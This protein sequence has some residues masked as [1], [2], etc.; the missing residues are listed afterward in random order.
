MT[1]LPLRAGARGARLLAFG[2][3]RPA[4]VVANDDLA[5]VM[6]TSDAW[7]RERTGI[8]TRHLAAPDE[9]V[10]TM[11]AAATAKALAASGV[12]A[13]EVDLVLLATCSA[14]RPIPGGAASVAATVGATSAG[15]VDVNAAC[16][17][18]CY[19][20]SWAADAVRSGSA[21]HVVVA[22]SERLSTWVD[23]TDRATAIL[24]GDGAGAA[25]V[26]PADVNAVGPV[27][28][29]SDGTR[30]A[31]IQ[32]PDDG[33]T[34][35]MDGPGVYRWATTE[36]AAVAR[37]ACAAAGLAPADVATFV[38]H[39]ANLRIVDSLAR[40]LGVDP[41]RVARDGVDTGNTSAASV[42]L[43]V[44]RLVEEGR[45]APGDPLL[46]LAFGAGLTYAAQVVLAP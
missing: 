22:G 7:I 21:R 6:D 37:E 17:G 19:G 46:L 15:A 34:L 11:A 44:A 23:P 14:T 41:A 31:A 5:A 8:V 1:G 28:W 26:G 10:V 9:T 35:R 16:A 40:Q 32:V 2:A 29:G 45:V 4:R 33:D 27:V 13:D 24:F 20:L 38:P 36:L 30:A 43:A 39:Q 25:V 12:A 42:P 3:H 18:F